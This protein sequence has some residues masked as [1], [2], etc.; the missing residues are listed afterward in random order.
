MGTWYKHS[1]LINLETPNERP[2]YVIVN[3]TFNR[4]DTEHFQERPSYTAEYF[5][6]S[7]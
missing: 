5:L 3:N 2:N 6:K 7:D 4:T 1:Y